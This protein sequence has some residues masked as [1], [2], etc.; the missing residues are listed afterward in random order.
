VA[1]YRDPY[2]TYLNAA[3]VAVAWIGSV[4]GPLFIFSTFGDFTHHNTYIGIAFII[5]VLLSIRDG[6]KA[7]KNGNTSG[8]I[9]MCV[10][11]LIIPFIVLATFLVI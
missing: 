4:L 3:G 1:F 10:M 11:P 6:V 7:K 5:V 2:V 9:A 8:F